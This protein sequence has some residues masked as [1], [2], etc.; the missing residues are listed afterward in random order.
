MEKT[1][2]VMTSLWPGSSASSCSSCFA[3]GDILVAEDLDR[4]PREPRAVDDAGVVQLVGEDEVLFAQDG[5]DRAGVGR[6]AALEDDA[7]FDVL[8]AGDLFFELHVD[9]HG[10]GDGAHGAGA[11]AERARGGQ[12]GLNELGVV[13]Q[14]QVVVAGQVDDF[15]PV[16]VADRGL[17]VVEDAEL[18]V[19]AL[20]AEFVE[21]LR[22][23]G[24]AG[25]E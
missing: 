16:V 6:K 18:E 1:P 19:G 3:V 24:R 23:D 17:L 13:G 11:H 12:R 20:G 8:E 2:S 5:A 14:A 9:A 21:D 22:S 15:A 7:G 10:S 25:G 4:R